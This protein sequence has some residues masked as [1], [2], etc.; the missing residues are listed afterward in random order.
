ML[1]CAST[2]LS[3]FFSLR[4]A[5]PV[6]PPQKNDILADQRR[7]SA[8]ES[9][10]AALA[11]SVWEQGGIGQRRAL[12]EDGG[13]EREEDRWCLLPGNKTSFGAMVSSG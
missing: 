4:S 1:T 9:Q 7:M 6:P 8:R 3:F 13:R 11:N 5:Y 2:H 10:M 12:G